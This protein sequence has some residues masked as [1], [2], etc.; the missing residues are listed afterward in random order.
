MF[1]FGSSIKL[2]FFIFTAIT[3][4]VGNDVGK[5]YDRHDRLTGYWNDN[6]VYDRKHRIKGFIQDNMLLDAYGTPLSYIYNDA[7]Y[8]TNGTPWAYYDGKSIRDLYGNRLGRGTKSWPGILS[9]ALIFGEGIGWYPRNYEYI[10]N[11]NREYAKPPAPQPQAPRNNQTL[12]RGSNRRNQND[13]VENDYRQNSRT[14]APQ[15][16]KNNN[17]YRPISDSEDTMNRELDTNGNIAPQNQSGLFGLINPKLGG[18]MKNIFGTGKT[19]L[20]TVGSIGG[21]GG[22]PIG[23][24]KVIGNLAGRYLMNNPQAAFSLLGRLSKMGFIKL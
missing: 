1:D 22:T 14:P 19:I 3:R 20:N 10:E 11:T 17:N 24:A 23:G 2:N 13:Y 5:I 16:A 8:T 6:V 4:K 18:S 9:S 7:F 21:Q 12:P 15:I